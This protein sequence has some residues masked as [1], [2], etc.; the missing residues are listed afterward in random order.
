MSVLCLVV[1]SIG[2]GQTHP[3][4]QQQR[5]REHGKAISDV[6]L[7]E[8]VDVDEYAGDHENERKSNQSPDRCL[9]FSGQRTI[10]LQIVGCSSQAVSFSQFEPQAGRNPALRSKPCRSNLHVS[11]PT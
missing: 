7:S 1:K 10:N 2:E 3:I 8:S 5:K 11:S 6:Q 9:L 4:R